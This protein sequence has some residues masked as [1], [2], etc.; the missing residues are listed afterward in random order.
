MERVKCTVQYDGTF[1]SGFQIQPDRRTVQGEIEGALQRMHRNRFIR[2]IASGRTD[3]GVHARGQV[4]HY[5]SDLNLSE[6][7]WKKALNSLLPDD[8]YIAAVEKVSDDFHARFDVKVKEYRY[9]I[10]NQKEP[11]LFNRYYHWHVNQ[12]LNVE[13][14]KEACRNIMGTHDFTSFSSTKTTIRGD[15]VRTMYN[16]DCL[17]E[18]N[19]IA[20]QVEGSGFLYNMV[21]IITGTL[22]EVGQGKK[23]AEEIPAIIE[24]KDRAL[25]GLTA[26]PQGLF[27]WKVTY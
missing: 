9:Q 21:R 10:L 6:D 15:K 3:T 12:S 24:Q 20:I 27:L 23:K 11:D 16:V 2:I 1:F 5:D 18:G 13:N 17:Q 8:I 4:F 22:V 26:P 25:A 14:M 19:R 7:K